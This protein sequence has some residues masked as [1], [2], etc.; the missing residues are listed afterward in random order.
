MS[1]HPQVWRSLLESKTHRP[2]D[3][4]SGKAS[5]HLKAVSPSA[6]QDIIVQGPPQPVEASEFMHTGN[7]LLPTCLSC[8]HIDFSAHWGREHLSPSQTEAE[9]SGPQRI[10]LTWWGFTCTISDSNSL[11]VNWRNNEGSLL[12][13]SQTLSWAFHMNQVNY[14]VPRT[15]VWKLLEKLGEWLTLSRPAWGPQESAPYDPWLQTFSWWSGPGGAQKG[16]RDPVSTPSS[17]SHCLWVFPQ[18]TPQMSNTVQPALFIHSMAWCGPGGCGE[19]SST[20]LSGPSCR[21]CPDADWVGQIVASPQVSA[22]IIASSLWSSEPVFMGSTSAWSWKR[23][24]FLSS[25]TRN[26]WLYLSNIWISKEK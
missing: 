15:Q 2:T 14:H 6:H 24:N 12:L 13:N 5:P 25:E 26:L 18:Q 20:G 4:G 23:L 16:L 8:G 11:T 10:H 17:F 22:K 1:N 19:L 7:P 9:F 21:S 3:S